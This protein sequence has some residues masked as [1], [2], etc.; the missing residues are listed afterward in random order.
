MGPILEVSNLMLKCLWDN[1]G[2]ISPRNCA[3]FELVIHHDPCTQSVF[4][5]FF[6]CFFPGKKKLHAGSSLIDPYCTHYLF[7]EF[8]VIFVFQCK[9]QFLFPGT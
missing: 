8:I 4:F 1:F 5:V 7:L 2:G 6:T 9:E 3:L